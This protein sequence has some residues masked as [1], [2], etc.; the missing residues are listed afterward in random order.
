MENLEL[1]LTS[2]IAFSTIGMPFIIEFVFTKIHEPSSSTL[3]SIWSWLIPVI[4]AYVVWGAGVWFD[5]GFL[6]EYETW[7]APLGY[8]VASGFFA[9]LGWENV[10]WLKTAILHVLGMIPKTKEE[11]ETK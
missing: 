3:K 6:A 7:Y 2:F 11:E 5:V 8:G 4:L 9:N 10:P 1:W